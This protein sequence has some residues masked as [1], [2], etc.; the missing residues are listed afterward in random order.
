MRHQHHKKKQSGNRTTNNPI[1][2]DCNVFFFNQYTFVKWYMF[3]GVGLWLIQSLS[4]SLKMNI[5]TQT[6][7][8]FK[9][10][11]LVQYLQINEIY[12]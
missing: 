4:H 12:N 10:I 1:D 8:L 3:R 9:D 5:T 11:N 2:I 7:F 6:S